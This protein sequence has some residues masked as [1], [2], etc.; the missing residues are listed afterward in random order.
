MMHQRRSLT[1]LIMQQSHHYTETTKTE[2]LRTKRIM[3]KVKRHREL[4][5]RLP[6]SMQSAMNL[7]T[8][9]GSS[10]WLSAL[11]IAEQLCI[12]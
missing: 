7:S 12:A 4:M 11:P 2:Q 1:A 8:E 6:G 9:K 5:D 10:S 3:T